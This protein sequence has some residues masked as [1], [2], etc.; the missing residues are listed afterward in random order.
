MA[1][2]DRNL[3]LAIFAVQLKAVPADKIVQAGAVWAL[4]PTRSM[5]D[6]LVESG[7][8]T[9][10]DLAFVEQLVDKAIEA[11][12]GNARTAL[13]AVGGD[14]QATRT[15]HGSIRIGK[16]GHVETV[17]MVAEPFLRNTEEMLS[18]AEE[19]PG[20]YSFISDYARGGMGR[21]LLVHDQHFGRQVAL[22][23]LLMDDAASFPGSSEASLDETVSMAARFLQEARVT[24]QLEHPSIV[25]VYELGRRNNG[26]LYYTMKFVRGR[27]LSHA[28]AECKTLIDRLNLL[29]HL[30][31]LCNAI[32]YAHSRSVIHRDIKPSNIMVGEFGE[33][34]VLDWGIAK[35]K[36]VEDAHLPEIRKT[37][38]DIQ[39]GELK[40][41]PETAYGRA[42]GTPNYMPPEQASG[43]LDEIDERSDVYSLGAV[44]YEVLTGDP[45]F[46]GGS[47]LEVML[48]VVGR[49]PDDIHTA[50]PDAP[51]ELVQICRK[52]MS[53]DRKSRYASA[54]ELA[55][56]IRR[57]QSGALVQAYKYTPGELIRHYYE[58]NRTVVNT[59]AAAMVLLIA[60]LAFSYVRIYNARN[61]EM[62]ARED[63]EFNG[64][65]S[66][67][68]L[69]QAQIEQGDFDQAQETLWHTPPEHRHWEW[70]HLLNR[71]NPNVLTIEEPEHRIQFAEYS[72]DGNRLLIASYPAPMSIWDARTG[73]RLQTLEPSDRM[74]AAAWTS[75]GTRIA[76]AS[77]GS[78]LYVWEA[79]SGNLLYDN[80]M[81]TGA[82]NTV[83]FAPDDHRLLS[84]SDD[85][86]VRVWDP[87]EKQEL[88]RFETNLLAAAAWLQDGRRFLARGAQGATVCA[89]D[90]GTP[91]FT[92]SGRDATPSPDDTQILAVQ[93]TTLYL[94]SADDG[95]LLAKTTDPHYPIIDAI[96]SHDS[97]FVIAA[98][99]DQQIYAWSAPELEPLWYLHQA[100]NME[101]VTL[102]PDD[103]YLAVKSHTEPLCV[104][105]LPSLQ[106]ITTYNYIEAWGRPIFH[107]SSGEIAITSKGSKLHVVNPRRTLFRRSV[108]QLDKSVKESQFYEGG[109]RVVTKTDGF[110]ACVDVDRGH[111]QQLFAAPKG[112]MTSFNVYPRG[113][114]YALLMPGNALL[115]DPELG[116]VV[117]QTRM[118]LASGRSWTY[119]SDL[120][121]LLT[122]NYRGDAQLL[123]LST[124]E[125]LHTWPVF[126]S[127]VKQGAISAQGH[128]ALLLHDATLLT[129][130]ASP[131]YALQDRTLPKW[132]FSGLFFDAAAEYLYLSDP[133][134]RLLQCDATTGEPLRAFV[135]HSQG[136]HSTTSSHDNRRLITL[137]ADATARYWDSGSGEVLMNAA[138]ASGIPQA[139][140]FLEDGRVRSIDSTGLVQDWFSYQPTPQAGADDAALRS[141]FERRKREF[142]RQEATP[143]ITPRLLDAPLLV[144]VPAELWAD[145][146][147][148]WVPEDLQGT[149]DSQGVVLTAAAARKAARLHLEAGD[150]VSSLQAQPVSNPAHCLDLLRA[151]S[152]ST[153]ATIEMA[154]VRNENLMRLRF[155]IIEIPVYH[156]T[157]SFTH[158][159]A[160]EMLD[161]EIDLMRRS[162]SLLELA[163]SQARA[164]GATLQGRDD[165][166]GFYFAGTGQP[167]DRSLEY[168]R[169]LG[170]AP[171]DRLYRL[172]GAPVESYEGLIRSYEAAKQ[173]LEAGQAFT[174]K[175]DVDRSEFQHF[176]ITVNIA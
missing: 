158:E 132:Q 74:N 118:E 152:S 30:I 11:H 170:L 33:T 120:D 5:G 24:G 169:A 173:L 9:P 143:Q 91:L 76:A 174:F 48:K 137:S 139:V 41:M 14:A 70:G 19:I 163:Q 7:A 172:N 155:H 154:V 128:L 16:T 108:L 96:W 129:G 17:P 110:T 18:T 53:K 81:H 167:D 84:A 39:L 75:D 151:A 54:M 116:A 52:A 114:Q 49:E 59:L 168:M 166:Q 47:V 97:K 78:A 60:V 63:A 119:A 46:H 138:W 56:E 145:Q 98:S 27:T 171:F 131:A 57:F 77:Q 87:N 3:L 112:G 123:H 124:G 20:R 35:L 66:Q 1:Q 26:T 176:V 43:R 44:L 130:R 88:V 107:P 85:G 4:Q 69:A 61:A 135:G 58:R 25:P 38:R 134:G 157:V 65:V 93:D 71:A 140:E 164:R 8:L 23:E 103:A 67:I 79:Q 165:I 136:V 147:L 121:L 99:Q 102:S 122:G 73:V 175:M 50:E 34:V 146:I 144:I 111:A 6:V 153:P 2:N 80:N 22:K 126:K 159:Q 72:P 86:T 83:E 100:P 115:Y 68:R 92:V 89:A 148:S 10:D 160:L 29:P 105:G 142:L 117:Q 62:E 95:H 127:P 133:Q 32:A 94:Y 21:V 150:Q 55:E 161:F 13:D 113:G 42:M 36:G 90:T 101:K 31:D 45:P 40:Q 141:D 12:Q 28:I 106:R 82:V 104:L 37:L 109:S 162:A 125:I 64:Y 15:F 149:D 51:R 156:R